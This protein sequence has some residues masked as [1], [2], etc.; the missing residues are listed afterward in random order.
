VEQL[1]IL[2]IFGAIAA[3]NHFLK[4]SREGNVPGQRNPGTP[5]VRPPS[6]RP[7]VRQ[8]EESDEERMRR[9]MEALGVPVTSAPPRKIERPVQPPQPV[10]IQQPAIRRPASEPTAGTTRP[11]VRPRKPVPA[12]PPPVVQPVLIHATHPP[13]DPATPFPEAAVSSPSVPATEPSSPPLPGE[14]KIEVVSSNLP[15]NIRA[16]LR[17]RDSIR[18]AILL[19]E[20][21]DS[22]RG[23]QSYR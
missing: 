23:L 1:V 15:M 8:S 6:Y 11:S 9:F 5:V 18:N 20:I 17:N 22:P 19:R 14:P 3:A 21:I 2:L 7:V 16:M 4:K 13:L 10:Q 12:V